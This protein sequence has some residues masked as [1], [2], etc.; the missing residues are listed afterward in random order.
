MLTIKTRIEKEYQN[1]V[2]LNFFIPYFK[3]IEISTD[4]FHRKI[5]Y[6]FLNIKTKKTFDS[7]RFNK[8]LRKEWSTFLKNNERIIYEKPQE[9]VENLFKQHPFGSLKILKTA[10]EDSGSSKTSFNLT[11]VNLEILHFLENQKENEEYL[12]TLFLVF[13]YVFGGYS[14]KKIIDLSKY[15]LES[16]NFDKET[17]ILLD[18]QV[19]TISIES[20]EFLAPHFSTTYKELLNFYEKGKYPSLASKL[21]YSFKEL[22]GLGNLT[23]NKNDIQPF[24]Q[25]RN[26]LDIS[27][28]ESYVV[29]SLIH[30]YFKNSL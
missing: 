22:N 20:K 13:V 27:D 16:I 11:K 25:L 1:F 6:L 30:H 18:K 10:S 26:Q 24:K 7:D 3:N 28:S 2:I 5:D 9:K 19:N 12:L 15:F 23:L 4:Y 29:L 14:P 8:T 21:K 17:R